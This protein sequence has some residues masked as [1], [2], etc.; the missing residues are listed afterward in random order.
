MI[1]QDQ[2]LCEAADKIECPVCL[3]I[4][5]SGPV[6]VCP[7]GHFVCKKCKAGSCP[8]C[9]VAMGEGKS[10]LA[11]TILESIEHSCKFEDCDEKFP[12]AH[13]EKHEEVC[14]CRLV[15]CLRKTGLVAPAQ[16]EKSSREY[17]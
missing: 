12:L 9:R 6:P 3:E 4:P 17:L 10:L 2:I 11:V 16:S 5:R 14:L 7:N 15:N 13:I 8:T 1:K